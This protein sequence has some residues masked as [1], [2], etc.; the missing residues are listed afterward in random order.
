MQNTNNNANDNFFGFLCYCLS[1]ILIDRPDPS[2]VALIFAFLS[3][4]IGTM[5]LKRF[6][7]DIYNFM[8]GFFIFLASLLKD[9]KNKS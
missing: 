4:I 2:I 3:L 8:H 6:W 5:K 9:L 1:I 7:G